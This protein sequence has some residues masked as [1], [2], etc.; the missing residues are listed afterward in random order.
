[1]VVRFEYFRF[2]STRSARTAFGKDGLQI[3]KGKDADGRAGQLVVC[4]HEKAGER[5]FLVDLDLFH[6]DELVETSRRIFH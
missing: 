1:M 5:V 4:R 6:G 3:V 2:R